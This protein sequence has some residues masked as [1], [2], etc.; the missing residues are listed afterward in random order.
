MP[1]PIEP[2]R[3]RA[4]TA[5]MRVVL[6][7]GGLVLTGLGIAGL[8]VPGLPGTPLLLA[9]AWM[10][11][12]SN[13]RLYRWMVG[14]R[15][16]GQAIADYRAGLGIP[17]RV[18]VTAITAMTLA[19]AASALL[20]FEAAWARLAVVALGAWGAWFIVTR[21]TRSVVPGETG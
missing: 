6:V 21:P 2:T 14:N 16:F 8:V 18:K 9:A 3:R 1:I 11:S 20:A 10:F 12:L 5:L 13:E 17:R 7:F 19:V 4:A 15:W